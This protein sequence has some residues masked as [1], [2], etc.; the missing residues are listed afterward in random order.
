MKIGDLV[1]FAKEHCSQGGLEYCS[2]WIGLIVEATK[3]TVHIQWYDTRSTLLLREKTIHQYY[4]VVITVVECPLD[5]GD[6]LRLSVKPGD[7]I[8][9]G[10]KPHWELPGV[11][12]I[13]L[14]KLQYETDDDEAQNWD[15]GPCLVDSVHK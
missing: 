12:G 11:L 8:L 2:D 15:G 9:Y 6:R 14:R 5:Y 1:K 4:H 10:T 13:L 3:E 7:L